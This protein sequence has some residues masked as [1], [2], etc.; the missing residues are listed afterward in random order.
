MRRFEGYSALVTGSGRGIGAAVATRL[1][2]EGAAVLVTDADGDLAR[3]TAAQIRADGGTAASVV[4]DVTDRAAVEA[5]VDA[6]VDGFGGLDILVNNAYSCGEDTFRFEDETD[7][8]WYRD[9]DA[10]LHGAFRCCRAALPHL[11]A[12]PDGRGAIV[13]IGSVNGE[14]DFGAHAYSAAKAGLA[15]L[16]RTLAGHCAPRGVRVNLVA[17]GTVRTEAWAGR[18]DSLEQAAAHFPLG[19]V[20]QPDDIAGAVAFLASIDAAWITGVTLPV[21]GGLLS[22]NLGL[23]RALGND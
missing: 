19:R 13:S 8:N 11:T 10:T 20:G 5:A 4:C 14:R 21:D 22:T 12:A 1:A 23:R 6:A 18:E 9:I 16:T 17:P 7:E 2:A 15:S 3:Y